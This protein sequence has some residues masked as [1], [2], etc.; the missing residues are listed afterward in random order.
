MSY[1][2]F[3]HK[4]D[5]IIELIKEP[6]GHDLIIQALSLKT[7]K[8]AVYSGQPSIFA[9]LASENDAFARELLRVLEK[10]DPLQS[11]KQ[12]KE[13]P[14]SFVNFFISMLDHGFRGVG[15][16]PSWPKTKDKFY[17]PLITNF[18]DRVDFITF[19][20]EKEQYKSNSSQLLSNRSV[21]SFLPPGQLDHIVNQLMT[22][23]DDVQLTKSN[24]QFLMNLITAGPPEFAL[25]LAQ[26]IVNNDSWT[27]RV[28]SIQNDE[29][30]SLIQHLLENI[31][32][33][34]AIENIV[35]ELITKIDCNT[36]SEEN[37]RNKELLSQMLSNFLLKVNK[38][39]IEM[40]L[41]K[42]VV[43]VENKELANKN[44][45]RIRLS[46][47]LGFSPDF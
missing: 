14:R 29:G 10:Y 40:L 6:V 25:K 13:N 8:K 41:S 34:T 16:P 15:P 27:K 38:R 19:S 47:N 20:K 33:D 9:I 2:L 46:H 37:D 7:P 32:P 30:I 42:L 1:S 31:K 5:Q 39:Q 3:K 4:G 35:N 17:K 12:K 22:S 24:D 28:L 18:Y 26:E 21:S 45:L 11:P 36:P 23:S 43:Q 44:F